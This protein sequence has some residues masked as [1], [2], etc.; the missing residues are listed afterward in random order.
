MASK[1]NKKELY[2]AYNELKEQQLRDS[3]FHSH[4]MEE[5][6]K[7]NE[8]LQKDISNLENIREE[9]C[10]RIIRIEKENEELLEDMDDYEQFKELK[11]VS[12]K[13]YKDNKQLNESLKELQNINKTIKELEEE[14]KEL[15]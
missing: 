2:K 11:E 10:Y 4:E 5:L 7:E 3:L 12:V 15:K 6:K 14:L 8:E 1:M 13:L 9:N